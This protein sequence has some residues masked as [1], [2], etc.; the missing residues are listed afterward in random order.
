LKE[1]QGRYYVLLESKQ[2]LKALEK[3]K[4]AYKKACEYFGITH[5]VVQSHIA[6]IKSFFKGKMCYEDTFQEHCIDFLEL[7]K[8]FK[9]TKG[10]YICKMG[11]PFLTK[12]KQMIR[13]DGIMDFYD[14]F[15]SQRKYASFINPGILVYF[16][17]TILYIKEIGQMIFV[18][19]P[20]DREDILLFHTNP[21]KLLEYVFLRI[22]QT[23]PAT[24]SYR[25]YKSQKKEFRFPDVC[26]ITLKKRILSLA[27]LES[28]FDVLL[29][30]LGQYQNLTSELPIQDPFYSKAIKLMTQDSIYDILEN[31]FKTK[32][33]T[34]N[35]RSKTKLED[36]LFCLCHP[37]VSLLHTIFRYFFNHH[38]FLTSQEK[39]KK[40]V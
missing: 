1:E 22:K 30:K 27:K 28:N 36:F 2:E 34:F 10:F 40:L 31:L 25:K 7:I 26:A 14:G 17:Q 35:L 23:K 5:P 16:Y 39:M 20:E 18:V 8:P 15:V 3:Q 38:I 12:S 4:I 37:K 13:T 19:I 6:F 21:V 32:I 9:I 24:S 33:K 11:L 29:E